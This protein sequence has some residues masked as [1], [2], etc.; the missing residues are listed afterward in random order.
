M[1]KCDWH[2]YDP[3]DWWAHE[4]RSFWC[5]GP[6][7][8]DRYHLGPVH[9]GRWSIRTSMG[10]KSPS[11][12]CWDPIRGQIQDRDGSR[13]FHQRR[14]GRSTKGT[15]SEL[16]LGGMIL[17][18]WNIGLGR[19]RTSPPWPWCHPISWTFWEA[20]LAVLACVAAWR[21][22]RRANVFLQEATFAL[23][24]ANVTLERGWRLSIAWLG[25]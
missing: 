23:Q 4:G 6:Y 12:G 1:M 20:A 3:C 13:A 11:G 17:S 16:D 7:S 14:R 22:P 8:T 24:R 15:L 19:P 9:M 2:C 25:F 10:M 21:S 18:Q 5:A